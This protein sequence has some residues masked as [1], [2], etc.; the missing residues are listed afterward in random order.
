MG[1]AIA[2][3]GSAPQS[4]FDGYYPWCFPWPKGMTLPEVSRRA[5]VQCIPAQQSRSGSAPGGDRLLLHRPL[6]LRPIG[7][8]AGL[9][10]PG[11]DQVHS[12]S[13]SQ[14][15][16]NDSDL[17]DQWR[18]MDAR[19]LLT[20]QH[21]AVNGAAVE[22][23]HYGKCAGQRTRGRVKASRVHLELH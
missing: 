20:G 10:L 6:E 13:A 15:E 2:N 19:R 16:G 1:T 22:I 7:R 3:L 5:C 8:G 12:W 21:D 18:Q 9:R 11:Q 17:V 4:R 14:H 23:C